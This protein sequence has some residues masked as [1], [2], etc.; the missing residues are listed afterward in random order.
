[1]VASAASFCSLFSHDSKKEVPKTTW[2]VTGPTKFR[3]VSEHSILI[4]D[5]SVVTACVLIFAIFI[6]HPWPW[7]AISFASLAGSALM[8][9]YS[10]RNDSIL[11]SVGLTPFSPRTLL[12]IVAAIP[13]GIAFGWLTRWSFDLTPLP[14]SIARFG[15]IAPLI[16]AME[17]LVFRGYIQGHLRPVG[18][19]TSIT[20]AASVHTCYK[21]LIILSLSIPLQFDIFF[22]VFW[23]FAGGT[24]F[25]IL[26]A[27]ARNSVPPMVAHAVFDIVLYGNY[28]AAPVWVWS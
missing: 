12:Y 24:V 23:T 9:S 10:L 5:V 25:G 6:H 17:E 21:L 27:G 8:V 26:R 18:R 4:R 11:E 28:P 1:M 13:L 16:G 7:R 3:R 14:R 20:I 19:F 22:L 15:Y 2:D